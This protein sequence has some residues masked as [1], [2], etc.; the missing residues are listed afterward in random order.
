MNLTENNLLSR[1]TPGHRLGHW[2]AQAAPRGDK[3]L[4]SI[5]NNPY[6]VSMLHALGG[7]P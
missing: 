7:L 4:V 6:E 3:Y 5:T 1:H 2:T